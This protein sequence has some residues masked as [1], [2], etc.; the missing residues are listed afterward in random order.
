MK[1]LKLLMS[2]FTVLVCYSCVNKVYLPDIEIREVNYEEYC[3]YQGELYSGKI[4]SS[5]ESCCTIVQNGVPIAA[6]VHFENGQVAIE[7]DGKT[8]KYYDKEGNSLSKNEF[9]EKYS[10]FMYSLEHKLPSNI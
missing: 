9:R 7:Y 4:Y 10:D 3:Y 1:T 5:D 2:L 6:Y 8:A